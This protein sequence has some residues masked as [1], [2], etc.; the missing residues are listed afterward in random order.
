MSTCCRARPNQVQGANLVKNP[1]ETITH[2]HFVPM[3]PSRRSDDAA[4]SVATDPSRTSGDA[5]SPPF[6]VPTEAIE[7]AK[8][9]PELLKGIDSLTTPQIIFK[10]HEGMKELA[11]PK[12]PGGLDDNV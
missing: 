12:R 4:H 6:S 5:Q 3:G 7:V 9:M 1:L 10:I 2:A 11:V 8:I